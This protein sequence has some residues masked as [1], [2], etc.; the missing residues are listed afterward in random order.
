MSIEIQNVEEEVV[1]QEASE[2][3]TEGAPEEVKEESFL[4]KHR[5]VEEAAFAFLLALTPLVVLTFF[6]Q[7]GLI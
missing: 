2:V 7:V 5:D 4:T 3:I 1:S 6:G